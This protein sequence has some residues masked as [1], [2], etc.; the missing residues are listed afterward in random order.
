[1][2]TSDK[3]GYTMTP[4]WARVEEGMLRAGRAYNAELVARLVAGK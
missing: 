3:Q 2:G 4:D 1:V